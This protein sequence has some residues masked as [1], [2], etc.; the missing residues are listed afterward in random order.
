MIRT[1]GNAAAD[2]IV[3]GS[4]MGNGAAATGCKVAR[5][6]VAAAAGECGCCLTRPMGLASSKDRLR[7]LLIAGTTADGSCCWLN[8]H[9][10]YHDIAKAY[11]AG[12]RRRIPETLASSRKYTWHKIVCKTYIR[13][14]IHRNQ[15]PENRNEWQGDRQQTDDIIV[16]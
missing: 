8:I 13:P 15:E 7:G 11:C 16:M 5:W 4:R 1:K 2:S 10:K 14:R 3:T 12:Q 9:R 6:K